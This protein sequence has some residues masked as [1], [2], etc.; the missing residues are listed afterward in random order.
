ME[1]FEKP[2]KTLFKDKSLDQDAKPPKEGSKGAAAFTVEKPWENGIRVSINGKEGSCLDEDGEGLEDS[3][4]NGVSSLLQMKG[5]VGKIDVNGGSESAKGF[6]TLL[7]AV[8]K[9]KEIG[10]E[11][12]FASGDDGVPAK[13]IHGETA[14]IDGKERTDLDG[15][16]NGDGMIMGRVD[17]I[18]DWG[19]EFSAGDFVWGKIRS[20]PW[21]PG[22]VYNPSDASDF[23]VKVRQKGRFL[24]AYFGDNS[25][26]WCHPSQ[27]KPFEENFEDMSKLS[28]SKNFLIAVQT[29]VD[30]I[31]RLVELKMTCSCV[32]KENCSGLDRPLAANA[33]I[34]K[35]VLVPEGGIGKLSFGL[36]EPEEI[37]GKLKQIAQA[38]SVSNLL[39]CTVLKGWVSAFNRSTGRYQMPTY[40]EP[41]SIPD[42]EENVRTLVVDM[43]DYSEAV[44]VPITGRV[45]EG[46][47]SSS[48]GPKFGQHSQTF[49]RCPEIL[50]N[51]MDQ[52][53]KQKSIA[54]IIKGE[55]DAQVRKDED[56]AQKGTNSGK[57]AS[58]SRTKKTKGKHKANGDD[59][60]NSSSIPRKRKG[61]ELSG[62]LTARKGKRSSAETDGTGAKEEEINNHPVSAKRKVNVGSGIGNSGA[63]TKGLIESGSLLR[64]R[65]K[66]KYLSP[67]YTSPAGKLRKMDIEA[68]SLK[69]SNDAQVGDQMTKAT[70]NL[71]RSPLVLDYSGERNQLPGEVHAEHKASN[72]S[73]FHMPEQY[74][75]S[76]ID[77]EKVNTPANEVL[78]EVQAI[79]LSPQY[80]RK[81]NSFKI[82]VEFLSV[83]RNSVYRHGSNYEI[84]NQFQP[85]TKRKYPDSVTGSSGQDRNL[86]DHVPYEHR[87]RQKKVG[88]KD[89]SNPR[90][91]TGASL[92]KTSEESKAHNP[93]I[94]QI[95]KAAVMKKN[96]NEVIENAS[97]AALFVTLGPGSPLPT[98]DDLIRIYSRFGDLDTEGTDMFYNNFCARVVFLRSSDAEQAFNSSQSASPFGAHNVSFRLLPHSSA[99]AHERRELPS[100]K[101]SPL[102]K[103][104]A[105]K[106]K[107]PSASQ[108]SADQTLQFNYIK[109][110]LEMLTSLLETTEEK[111]SSEIKS[112]LQSEMKGLLEKVNT[113]V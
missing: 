20:H 92:K 113:M 102:A 10:V 71:V 28:N 74:L 96:D 66:S 79:A 4:M 56:V 53:R 35:G 50:E 33:G 73:S 95:A 27:L 68:E 103:D 32:P 21:W 87:S 9:S 51:G 26:A 47:V 8:D 106:S 37:L 3:E 108:S 59:G 105:K 25:F 42:L 39:E 100:A 30:E 70:G 85:H 12:I 88:K 107:K 52:R 45:E 24:V 94:K 29:S 6:G 49:L 61:T 77:L 34:K 36:F 41:P 13:D 2:A 11:N 44:E 55:V 16:E 57:Q 1:A 5:S 40:H 76:M 18:D 97:P 75:N 91:A 23:A 111:M 7:G 58:S 99:S 81:N 63:E 109:H 89:Q 17:E 19:C 22:Q 43:S 31:G 90:Q 38:V 83:F 86:T 93:K 112:K 60:S 67:P 48:S 101:A 110:K 98:K 80:R 15:K 72:G 64:E 69:V 14:E 54:E 104:G 82:V 46:W 62:S 84:Y 65:K 78:I